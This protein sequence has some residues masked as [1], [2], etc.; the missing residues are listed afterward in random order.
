MLGGRLLT[1]PVRRGC[2]ASR[3]SATARRS[4]A[5]ERQ[6]HAE[7]G[8]GAACRFDVDAP[9][10]P[11]HDAVTDAEAET[12]AERV[13]FGREEGLEDA[14]QDLGL[15]AGAGVTHGQLGASATFEL[16]ATSGECQGALAAHGLGGVEDEVEHHLAERTGLDGDG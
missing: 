3:L 5:S 8:A 16:A 11:L 9:A 7:G 15:D 1:P 6:L 10:M 12:G 2:T 4:T 13:A 14:R